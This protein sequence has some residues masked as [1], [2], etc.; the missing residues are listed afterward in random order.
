MV[1][2]INTKRTSAY[3]FSFS[4]LIVSAIISIFVPPNFGTQDFIEYWSAY[5]IFIGGGNPYSPL[6]MGAVQREILNSPSAKPLMM[7]N[8]PWLLMIF[9][10]VFWWP[11]LLASKLFICLQLV[12]IGLGLKLLL[13]EYRIDSSSKRLKVALAVGSFYPIFVSLRLGQLG[14]VLFFGFS[15]LI[16]SVSNK[17]DFLGALGI[18][19]LSLKP[20]LAGPALL[21]LSFQKDLRPAFAKATILLFL[22]CFAALLVSPNIILNWIDIISLERL[23]GIVLPWQWRTA[24]I[25]SLVATKI[26]WIPNTVL[27]FNIILLIYLSLRFKTAH[28]TELVRTLIII[29]VILA[30]FVWIFD[31]VILIPLLLSSLLAS[32]SKEPSAAFNFKFIAILLVNLGA[33]SLNTM[34]K[35][36]HHWFIWHGP[37]LLLIWLLINRPNLFTIWQERL[38]AR[39]PILL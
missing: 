7:F 39:V 31:Q 38:R 22:S 37:A 29:S 32:K 27:F 28:T 35:L 23:S 33:W 17:K 11:F 1:S 12:F 18:L 4:L 9:A 34:S 5:S 15:L 10:P 26:R 25:S 21:V 16:Y 2:I 36:P 8:P 20:H 19:I 14:G 6:E 24:S 3:L 13:T 30:P